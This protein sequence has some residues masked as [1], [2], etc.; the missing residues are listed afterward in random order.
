MMD[1][2][3]ALAATLLVLTGIA[4][5]VIPGLPGPPMTYCALL[6]TACCGF[7]HYS[8][9]FLLGWGVATAAITALDY[10]LPAWVT[11]R[12]GGSRLAAWGAVAG[13]FIGLMF[14]PLGVVLGPFFGALAGELIHDSSDGVR[15]LRVAFGALLSFIIGTG[16]KLVVSGVM[17]FFI[18]RDMLRYFFGA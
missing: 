18:F 17:S 7:G 2:V 1:I 5:C 10:I 16:A 8:L 3:L 6:L 9:S 14:M 11:R 13:V 12:A 4:G 15:A